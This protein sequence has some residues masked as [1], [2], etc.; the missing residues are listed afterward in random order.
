MVLAVGLAAA[1]MAA[2]YRRCDPTTRRQL[3][4]V[5]IGGV[6]WAATLAPFAIVRYLLV[7]SDEVGT[8]ITSIAA[9]GTLVIPITIYI[10]TLRH[11]LFGVQAILGRTLVYV[12]LMGICGGLYAAGLALSQRVFV[13][14]TGNTSDVAII[15]ATLLMAA[16][17]TPARRALEVG[18]ER[19][20][21]ARRIAL[22]ASADA[23]S[24]D[25]H[26]EHARLTSQAVLFAARLAEIE[27]QIAELDQPRPRDV[28][29]EVGE[30]GVGRSAA[31]DPGEPGVGLPAGEPRP[32]RA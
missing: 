11:H 19:L 2:R 22:D 13:A 7:V 24:A 18:V 30:P 16:A 4:W 23:A 15:V 29:R 28:A 5:A 17:F 6:I 12:P 26:A 27:H 1:A 32:G 9:A 31:R 14:V 21:A 10:A 20:L 8:L 25:P 3:A